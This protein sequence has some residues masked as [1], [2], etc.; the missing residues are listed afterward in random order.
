MCES[1]GEV[2]QLSVEIPA[3]SDMC[4]IWREKVWWNILIEMGRKNDACKSGG[5]GENGRN[6][7]VFRCKKFEVCIGDYSKMTVNY[8]PRYVLY[9]SFF[10]LFSL[11]F[12]ATFLDR[13]FLVLAWRICTLPH[14]QELDYSDPLESSIP[15]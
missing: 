14:R 10:F 11:F 6:I 8:F 1:G 7:C 3:K 5:E 4:D 2:V 12:S 13:Y 9:I 15:L